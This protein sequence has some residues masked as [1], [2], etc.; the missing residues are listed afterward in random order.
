MGQANYIIWVKE[1]QEGNVIIIYVLDM[2][3][4]I[5]HIGNCYDTTE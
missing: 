4:S 1:I 2:K 3:S 5:K